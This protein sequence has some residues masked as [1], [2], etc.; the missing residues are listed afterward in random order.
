[1][2]SDESLRTLFIEKKYLTLT[3]LISPGVIQSFSFVFLRLTETC[4]E[5]F[6]TKTF[7]L[8]DKLQAAT[9]TSDPS[10]RSSQ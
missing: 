6:S 2:K 4:L 3:D 7:S 9:D 5:C 1:M 10:K 8:E